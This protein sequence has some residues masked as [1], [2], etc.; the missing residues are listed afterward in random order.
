LFE[1]LDFEDILG[2][3][4]H[5]DHKGAAAYYAVGGFVLLLL[6]DVYQTGEARNQETLMKAGVFRLRQMLHNWYQQHPKASKVAFTRVELSGF[7]CTSAFTR[8]GV[9][10]PSITTTTTTS[11]TTTTTT[12]CYYFYYI[13]HHHDHNHDDDDNDDDDSGG[14]DHDGNHDDYHYD[15]ND[16]NGDVNTGHHVLLTTCYILCI[17]GSA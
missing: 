2:D 6:A 12:D 15:Y 8:V 11:T 1:V 7:A 14:G 3:L 5:T 9:V 10:V 4:L 13:N 17:I 16:N